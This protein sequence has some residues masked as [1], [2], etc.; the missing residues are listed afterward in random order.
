MFMIPLWKNSFWGAIASPL[1]IFY[2]LGFQVHKNLTKP[3]RVPVPVI[4]VGNITVGG[5]GKTP[6]VIWLADHLEKKGMNVGIL[7]RGYGRIGKD[8]VEVSDGHSIILDA[9]QSGDEPMLMARRL[10]HIPLFVGQDRAKAAHMA[11]QKMGCNLLILDDG[12]QH[13]RLDRDL[14]IVTVD[15]T[16]AWGNGRMIPAGPLR[17]PLNA[18]RRAKIIMLTRSAGLDTSHIQ[19]RIK[20]ITNAPILTSSHEP[21][22]WMDVQTDSTKSLDVLRG[23]RVLAFSGIGNPSA[24]MNTLTSLN[25]D[26]IQHSVFKDHHW[27]TAREL[28]RL[29]EKAKHFHVNAMVTTEKDA[30]RLPEINAFSIPLFSLR[31]NLEIKKGLHDLESQLNYLIQKKG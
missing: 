23:K 10:R 29:A 7:S 2:R 20:K 6:L 24:F 31:I 13:H 27:Y 9:A 5:T 14:D 15:A 26:V 4:S 17:E 3:V 11:I 12:F 18:V 25:L 28:D 30:V 16:N 21:M 8:I 22:D 1:S 19:S